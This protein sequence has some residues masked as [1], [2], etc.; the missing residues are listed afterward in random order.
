MKLKLPILIASLCLLWGCT[1][2]RRASKA[3]PDGDTIEVVIPEGRHHVQQP[4]RIIEVHE[5]EIKLH[6]ADMSPTTITI[7]SQTTPGKD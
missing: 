1:E 6:D 2:R 7:G 5:E 4:V 3:T